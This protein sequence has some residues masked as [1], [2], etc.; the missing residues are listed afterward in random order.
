MVCAMGELPIAAPG[1]QLIAQSDELSV[2]LLLNDSRYR[3][4][5]S[6]LGL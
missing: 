6:V 1:I 4:A 5:G 3:T 2:L